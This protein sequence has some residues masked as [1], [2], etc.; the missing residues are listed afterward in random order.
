MAQAKVCKVTG[1]LQYTSDLQWCL[2]VIVT[3]DSH[4][5]LS[6]KLSNEVKCVYSI[7]TI[8]CKASLNQLMRSCIKQQNLIIMNNSRSFW[9]I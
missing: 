2:T 9:S 8:H 1:K 6:A 7:L 3:D 4:E 5:Q